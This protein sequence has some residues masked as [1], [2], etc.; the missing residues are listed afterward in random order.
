[1]ICWHFVY[2]AL[3]A[4]RVASASATSASALNAWTSRSGIAHPRMAGLHNRLHAP[5][6]ACLEPD[7][8]TA[9]VEGGC[10]QDVLH[11]AT[12][13]SPGTL[14]VLLRDV[15]PEP[16]L[17]VF[18]ILPMHACAAFTCSRWRRCHR[19]FHA[20]LPGYP[21]RNMLRCHC[22]EHTRLRLPTR[23]IV[24]HLA[25][26]PVAR[27]DATGLIPDVLVM[28]RCCARNDDIVRSDG[29]IV[30]AYRDVIVPLQVEVFQ[31]ICAGDKRQHLAVISVPVR[32]QMRMALPINGRYYCNVRRGEIVRD[33]LLIHRG[34]SW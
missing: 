24:V 1:M 2:R 11:D 5:H 27:D 4:A 3:V 16:W 33:L 14:V 32:G 15:H 21:C 7:L 8:D 6:F 13:Q 20:N 30:N 26:R 12:G 34:S 17:D 19:L 23:H 25:R 18:A 31:P 28:A 22:N 9:R 10:C 29:W